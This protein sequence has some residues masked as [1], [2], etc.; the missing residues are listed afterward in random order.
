MSDDERAA[1][2]RDLF[3]SARDHAN[4]CAYCPLCTV[5]AAVR[6]TR[7]DLMSHLATAAKELVLA[8]GIVME[9]AGEIFSS[10]ASPEPGPPVDVAEV[11]RIDAL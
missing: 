4:D 2:Y 5:I 7:P 9:E 1:R 11:R 6:K 8:A 10:A 3:G